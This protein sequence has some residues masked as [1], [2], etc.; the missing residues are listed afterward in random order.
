MA[1]ARVELTI[2]ILNTGEVQVAG[3]I[4]DKGTCYA[5][6][7]LARDAIKE[8]VDKMTRSA[9]VPARPVDPFLMAQRPNGDAKGD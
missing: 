7:E 3:P 8:H 9:I 2:R 5:L 1:T 6:L 4:H